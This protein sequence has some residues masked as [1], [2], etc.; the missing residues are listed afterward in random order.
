MAAN[1]GA[2]GHVYS[3]RMGLEGAFE[4]YYAEDTAKVLFVMQHR[5]PL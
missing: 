2:M 4:A 3:S 5:Q 1:I